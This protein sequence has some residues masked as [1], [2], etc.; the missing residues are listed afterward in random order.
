M[1]ESIIYHTAASFKPNIFLVDKEPT[2]LKGEVVTTLEMLR[3]Q[4]TIN[5]LGLRDIMDDSS[6]LK[7]E[8][9]RK[10]V[11][12]VLENL[13][14]DI[15][16]YGLKQMGNPVDSLD[17]PMSITD[18]ITHTGYLHREMPNEHHWVSPVTLDQ[19]FILVTPGGGGDGAEMV[20]W[21]IS[22][23][24]T[25]QSI[26]YPAVIV[27]CP[28]MPQINQQEFNER[29]DIL[30]KIQIITFESHIEFLM[31]QAIGIVAMGGYNTFC[32]ILSLDKR[33]LIVPRSIPR[34][35]Q[36]IR[37]SRAVALE[38]VSMLDPEQGRDP[39]IMASALHRLPNQALP[40][41][42]AIDGLLDGHN[43]IAQLTLKHLQSPINRGCKTT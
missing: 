29:C 16:V 19:P 43:Q 20:D 9:E 37:A 36:L 15:W 14:H 3:K 23:Y 33:A 12:P 5:V 27:T 39:A 21:V 34:K 30:D 42:H 24:E 17:L 35:E 7:I 28:F 25:D 40:S 10:Q 22:A 11:Q 6:A 32:E 38:L 26:S 41:E 4:G 2:G 18:K 8:W 1:R 31:E 13:Y